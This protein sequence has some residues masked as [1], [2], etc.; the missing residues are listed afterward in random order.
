MELWQLNQSTIL[1]V[2]DWIASWF[3]GVWAAARI[4]FSD[5]FILISLG[6]CKY[7]LQFWG[8]YYLFLGDLFIMCYHIWNLFRHMS[9]SMGHHFSIHGFILGNLLLFFLH[10]GAYKTWQHFWDCYLP[11]FALILDD[12]KDSLSMA[13]MGDDSAVCLRISQNLSKIVV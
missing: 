8:I 6:N 10:H 2:G 13:K 3:P 11:S 4:Y 12:I 9:C 5:F 7:I 1:P